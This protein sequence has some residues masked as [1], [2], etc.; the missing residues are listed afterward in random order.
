MQKADKGCKGQTKGQRAQN[1]KILVFLVVLDLFDAN[2]APIWLFLSF[3]V[4]KAKKAATLAG[5]AELQIRK[6]I[7]PKVHL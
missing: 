4:I 6:F 5:K 7:E 3:K 2:N 1:V